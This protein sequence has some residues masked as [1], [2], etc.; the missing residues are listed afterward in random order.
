MSELTIPEYC[1]NNNMDELCREW[2]EALERRREKA[3]AKLKD[4]EWV[5]P[6]NWPRPAA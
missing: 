3:E 4:S 5:A 1:S 2:R 6:D